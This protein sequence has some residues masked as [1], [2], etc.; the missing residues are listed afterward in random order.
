MDFRWGKRWPSLPAPP[1]SWWLRGPLADRTR[2][3]VSI[4]ERSHPLLRCD[5]SQLSHLSAMACPTTAGSS[6]ENLAL[7]RSDVAS[8]RG[9]GCSARSALAASFTPPGYRHT[10]GARLCLSVGVAL[11][12]AGGHHLPGG[13]VKEALW[14]EEGLRRLDSSSSGLFVNGVSLGA[15]TSVVCISR[16]SGAFRWSRGRVSLGREFFFLTPI[17]PDVET[18]PHPLTGSCRRSH[19]LSSGSTG[20]CGWDVV[21]IPVIVALSNLP[22]LWKW[23]QGLGRVAEDALHC[24]V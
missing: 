21:F 4:L 5:D 9:D 23:R 11:C 1:C 7:R 2:V 3:R 16:R 18:R 14:T 13:G 22:H 10:C 19:S 8:F 12:R 15:Q 17:I 24:Q 20:S 6:S